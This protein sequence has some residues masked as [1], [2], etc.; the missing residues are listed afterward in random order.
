MYWNFPVLLTLIFLFYNTLFVWMYIFNIFMHFLKPLLVSDIRIR[1][2]AWVW[3]ND[4]T[5][6]NVIKDATIII[7]KKI[8]LKKRTYTASLL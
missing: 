6:D 1:S 5:K 4:V 2:P 3:K 7:Y 8:F